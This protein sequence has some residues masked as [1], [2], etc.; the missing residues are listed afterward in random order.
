MSVEMTAS[1]DDTTTGLWTVR[2]HTSAYVLDLDSRTATRVPQDSPA[3]DGWRTAALR[4]DS[5]AVPLLHLGRC[6]VGESMR[7]LV[8]VVGDGA[9]ATLRAT[10]PVLSI[11][12]A[13]DSLP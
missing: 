10:T 2:T 9:T 13:G 3:D 4:L 8:D 6:Q 12:Q 1:I 5:E 11:E 7:M